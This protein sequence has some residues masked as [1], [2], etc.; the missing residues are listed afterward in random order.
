MRTVESA[1]QRAIASKQRVFVLKIYSR[2]SGHRN[3]MDS[4][5]CINGVRFRENPL[6][7]LLADNVVFKKLQLRF[8]VYFP[9]TRCNQSG[10]LF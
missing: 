7:L 4:Y 1:Q 2:Y 6:C 3:E 9:L 8:K 5:F 10:L